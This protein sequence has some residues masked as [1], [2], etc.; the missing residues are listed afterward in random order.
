MTKEN[1]KEIKE[2]I[3][4][5]KKNRAKGEFRSTEDLEN[6]LVSSPRDFLRVLSKNTDNPTLSEGA[7]LLERF[8]I[9]HDE[10]ET[11][12]AFALLQKLLEHQSPL[13]REGAVY[14]LCGYTYEYEDEPL[15]ATQQGYRDAV[16]ELLLPITLNDPSPG[17][18]TAAL[19]ALEVLKDLHTI[20]I[21]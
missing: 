13:V 15:N 5:Y 2:L 19:E 16:Q 7:E 17:V 10:Q 6:L 11:R 20:K 9:D 1:E 8:A 21:F 3:E 12:E 14:G 4:D 18:R